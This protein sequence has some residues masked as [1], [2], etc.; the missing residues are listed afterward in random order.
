V[1]DSLLAM[2]NQ[3]I[4]AA[5]LDVPTLTRDNY[6]A[7]LGGVLSS[8]DENAVIATARSQV[9]AA[10][11]A[12]ES[13]VRE[14]VTAAVE[15]QVSQ[16]VTAAVRAQV[17]QQ[18]LASM[19]LAAV[20]EG[21]QAQIDAAVDQQMDT[22]Q[23]KAMVSSNLADQMRSEQVQATINE[24]TEEQIQA[25]IDQNMASD[26]V[27]AQ[28]TAGLEQAG[29]GAQQLQSLK[30]QL[31][32]YNTFY[33]GLLSYTAGVAQAAQGAGKLDEAMPDFLSGVTQLQ[34]GA[35]QLQDGL[36]QFNEEGIS[37]LTDAFKD[38]FQGLLD[39]LRATVDAAKG[40]QTF[41]GM[42][43]NMDGEVKFIYKTGAIELP[44][45]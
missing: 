24:K 29:S 9:E 31:D 43:D 10:V 25:L 32:S 34:D 26:E 41:A 16:Q 22:D 40:Y 38:D 20:P 36:K 39:R 23:V 14:A 15:E 2:A 45:T 30:A 8:L 7:V 42:G 28:I 19:G 11:R 1:F 27:Q 5:G 6:A 21:M 35:A 13:T 44:E 3:Q 17:E 33:K 37:K 18:V 12:N 4:A